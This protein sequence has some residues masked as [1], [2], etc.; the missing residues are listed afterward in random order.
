VFHVNGGIGGVVLDSREGGLF[1]KPFNSLAVRAAALLLSLALACLHVAGRPR[2][3]AAV[4]VSVTLLVAIRPILRFWARREK[5]GRGFLILGSSEQA[6]R[7]YEELSA[8][9]E[10]SMDYP[11]APTGPNPLVP[12]AAVRFGE[13]PDLALR[14][15]CRTIVVAELDAV[16][17]SALAPA[18]LDCKVQGI[19]IQEAAGS[20][21][22]IARKVWLEALLPDHIVYTDQYTP[23]RL[24][25]RVKCVVD[26]L[27]AGVFAVLT[28]PLTAAVALA[29]K[30]ESRGPVFF[31]Q[32]RLGCNGTAIR[33]LKFRSMREE[34]ES[35]TGPVWASE[36]D[37]RVTF[38]GRF[39]RKYRIDELPQIFNVLLGQM[40][41]VGPR[42]ER[43]YFAGMLREH[44]DYYDLRL[45]VKPGIT[46]WAQ[47][48]YAY[49]ASVQDAYEKLQYDLYYL[50]HM[51][52]LL[53]LRIL[54]HTVVVVL[55]GRGR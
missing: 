33:V 7:L 13:I 12:G 27:L 9:R 49:G 38:T 21:E 46:G 50:K 19:E 23:R 26:F 1:R 28:A 14:H 25:L 10:V 11:F 48:M 17:R 55:Q 54:L 34:A 40:S 4:L 6:H 5:D 24:Y 44:I 42:P 22:Q 45:C 52:L 41:F 16:K 3:L 20:Y 18:L 35:E 39:L 37:D 32:V 29:I 51:S 47:V 8:A 53:D 15:N 30:L 36:E 43:P 2:L 31:R